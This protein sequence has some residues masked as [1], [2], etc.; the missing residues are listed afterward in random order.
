VGLSFY[1]LIPEK[2]ETVTAITS[3]RKKK[4]TTPVGRFTYT[5]L[6][7]SKY[8]IGVTQVAVAEKQ[9]AIIATK[10]KALVDILTCRKK[11][12]PKPNWLKFV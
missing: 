6:N 12:K 4:F 10:E 11:L 9:Y 3:K 5:Y 7:P 8:P 1:G 2:V